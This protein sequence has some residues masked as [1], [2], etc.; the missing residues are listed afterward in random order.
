MNIQGILIGAIAF[1]IIGVFHPIVVNT[2]YRFGTR[3]WPVFLL[4]GILTLVL[5]LFVDNV[6]GSA[7]FGVFGFASLWS[8]REIFEQA[9]RVERGWFPQNPKREY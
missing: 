9:Q 1:V 6:I 8:I 4:V 5:S 7:A 3:I 2:E